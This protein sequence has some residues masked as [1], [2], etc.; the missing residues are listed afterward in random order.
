MLVERGVLNSTRR[1]RLDGTDDCFVSELALLVETGTAYGAA[2]A[3]QARPDRGV[4]CNSKWDSSVQNDTRRYKKCPGACSGYL[5]HL[6][7]E[8]P[9]HIARLRSAHESQRQKLADNS[10]DERR[11]PPQELELSLDEKVEHTEVVPTSP[12]TPFAAE[13]AL[14]SAL[15]EMCRQ[16]VRYVGVL[17]TDILD[18]LFL[19]A[20]V[21][22]YCPSVR[23]F[24]LDSDILYVHPKYGREL[25]GSLVVSPYPLLLQNRGW[26]YPFD[27]SALSQFASFTDQGQYNAV[28]RLLA[29]TD[30]ADASGSGSGAAGSGLAYWPPASP[31]DQQWG[32]L[33]P[34][35]DFSDLGD[36]PDSS[37]KPVWVTAIGNASFWPLAVLDTNEPPPCTSTDRSGLGW[38]SRLKV[39]DDARWVFSST[40]QWRVFMRV[41]ILLGT[42]LSGGYWVRRFWPRTNPLPWGLRWA[43]PF[44]QASPTL[45]PIRTSLHIFVALAPLSLLCALC[46][47]TAFIEA[48][49][50]RP[51]G[52]LLH[53]GLIHS[54]WLVFR[55]AESSEREALSM[56]ALLFSIAALF[57]LAA[58]DALLTPLL[59][60]PLNWLR[61]RSR[62]WIAAAEWL[63]L[64]VG[65][66]GL[67]VVLWALN[68]SHGIDPLGSVSIMNSTCQMESLGPA[69]PVT[70]TV[71][72]ILF[73][74]R[75][76]NLGSGVSILVPAALLAA[77]LLLCGYLGVKMRRSPTL[78]PA[79][80][81]EVAGMAALERRLLQ[82]LHRFGGGGVGAVLAL[83]LPVLLWNTSYKDGLKTLEGP[84]WDSL[85]SAAALGGLVLV[86]GALLSFISG[87]RRLRSLLLRHACLP[88]M[89]AMELL[90]V[91]FSRHLGGMLLARPP[92]MP[93]LAEPVRQLRQLAGQLPAPGEPGWLDFR[94]GIGSELAALRESLGERLA[95]V[96]VATLLASATFHTMSQLRYRLTL[97]TCALLL[98]LLTV[99]TYPFER[100]YSLMWM[101]EACMM[102][103]VAT[104]VV[105][106]VQMETSEVLSRI[107]RTKPGELS[108]ER[109]FV[110]KLVLF[111]LV[112]VF[113]VV[114]ANVPA[115]G[116][117]LFG[118]VVPLLQLM[119]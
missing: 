2:A 78:V 101:T 96:F 46:A 86:G 87:W 67:A 116:Q 73:R 35:R 53:G 8:Y 42:L 62:R 36:D 81:L 109:P 10:R 57:A 47:L 118:W 22:K 31:P 49:M 43:E 45:S 71:G 55:Q 21:K 105:A 61:P 97:A 91:E 65:M 80:P 33:P 79:W 40:G 14:E 77:A 99:L 98:L 75:T 28:L 106:F 111:V 115:I 5:P 112:P 74:E 68:G 110:I 11:P 114:A 72:A 95:E 24:F 76:G 13:L 90:P 23:L 119:Q 44:S 102:A 51:M 1:D 25:S 34:F 56:L 82:T 9:A 89:R 37:V 69:D 6:I 94:D 17:G 64:P 52:G 32:H 16:E 30:A 103:V 84:G 38:S 58:V 54:V 117:P 48:A 113:S 70:R 3:T 108:F 92:H 18:R 4:F 66:L 59:R 39:G 83:A 7:V 85:I 15:A 63:A 27:S 107:Q 100:Q 93:E 29:G 19:A 20:E 60:R 88:L 12:R 26:S 50:L 41:L 104:A